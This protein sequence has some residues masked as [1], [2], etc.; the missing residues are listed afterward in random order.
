M[1]RVPED[2]E[3]VRAPSGVGDADTD[4]R[5]PLAEKGAAVGIVGWCLVHPDLDCTS[6][7]LRLRPA[8]GPRAGLVSGA[9][10]AGS[11][12]GSVGTRVAAPAALG[13]V[14]R[15][16]LRGLFQC[17]VVRQRRDAM[18]PSDLVDQPSDL[19]RPIG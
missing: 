19:A 4:F 15:L 3:D 8:F 18:L 9:Q 16:R 13:A 10:D 7:R 12:V 11:D 6:R 2:S 17:G 5:E 1:L 14:V